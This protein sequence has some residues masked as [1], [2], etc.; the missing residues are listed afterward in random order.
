[1]RKFID[2]ANRLIEAPLNDFE[3]SGSSDNP[4]SFRDDD[5][6]AFQNPK[7]LAKVR[8]AFSRTPFRI[9]VYAFNGDRRGRVLFHHQMPDGSHHPT[10]RL[11][12]TTHQEKLAAYVGILSLDQFERWFGHAPQDTSTSISV[13][14]LQN[15][16][17]GRMPMTPWV[18]AHRLGHAIAYAGDMNNMRNTDLEI[19]RAR[20]RL[21]SSFNNLTYKLF[22]SLGGD[23]DDQRSNLALVGTTRA[24]RT[25]NMINE[26]EFLIDC[27]AQY[28]I[29]G[30]VVFSRPIVEPLRDTIEKFH[31]DLTD[32]EAM[33]NE[34]IEKLLQA[35]VGKLLVI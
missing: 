24:I 34:R 29:L 22:H 26:G 7:W 13:V 14:F 25:G 3:I 20:F 18:L 12:K 28:L 8:S 9:N 30:K 21:L 35:C 19:S 5:L 31:N 23:K 2:A 17:D 11:V 32:S 27:V 4:G 10:N 16:G 33:F 6:R 15:E 1:M